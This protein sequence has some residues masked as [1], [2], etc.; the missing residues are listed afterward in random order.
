MRGITVYI[1]SLEEEPPRGQKRQ[2]ESRAGRALL[3]HALNRARPESAPLREADIPPLLCYG[4]RG[5]PA[6]REPGWEFNISHSRGL[7]ACGLSRRALGLDLERVRPFPPGLA[8]R[9]RAP[10]EE[11][12]GERC[13]DP[14]SLWTQLWTCKESYMKYTGLGM[15]QDT[16]GMRFVR[17]GPLPELWGEG[18]RFRSV[19]L[20]RGK[21]PFWLTVCGEEPGPLRAELVPAGQIAALLA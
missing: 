4:P 8:G 9:I 6:L 5:K 2:A 21:E 11:A 7:V 13:P 20:L 19:R 15:S 10:G 18:P 16:A 1:A 14:D 12:L 3:A 17:L